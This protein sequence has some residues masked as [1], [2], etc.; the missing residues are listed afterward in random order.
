MN[1]LTIECSGAAIPRC[2]LLAGRL[3]SRLLT[4]TIF[5]LSLPSRESGPRIEPYGLH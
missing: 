3:S 5:T 4:Y 1:V 2:G